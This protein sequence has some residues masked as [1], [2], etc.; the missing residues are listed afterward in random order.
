LLPKPQNPTII[1]N[2]NETN[3][4]GSGSLARNSPSAHL[5]KR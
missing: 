3:F 1:I 2:L 5:H 4:L